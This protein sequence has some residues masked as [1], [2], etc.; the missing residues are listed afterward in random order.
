MSTG[1]V[2]DMSSMSA[3]ATHLCLSMHDCTFMYGE[4]EMRTLIEHVWAPHLLGDTCYRK[5]KKYRSLPASI[6]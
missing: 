5:V 3:C 2:H 6:L 1:F 4:G